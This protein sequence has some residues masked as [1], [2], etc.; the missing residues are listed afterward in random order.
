MT[1]HVANLTGELC[2]TY[3]CVEPTGKPDPIDHSRV[4]LLRC[5]CGR[6]LFMPLSRIRRYQKH[7]LYPRCFCPHYAAAAVNRGKRLPDNRPRRCSGCSG[8]DHKYKDCP[9]R[10]PSKF[11]WRCCDMTFR[12][13]GPKCRSCG[14]VY[15]PEAP[16]E[17]DVEGA[18]ASSIA[19]CAEVA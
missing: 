19:R 4:W 14:L 3:R 2:G 1:R 7:N 5:T 8:T 11:C 12:V 10:K 6:E 18:R 15:A 16:V 17:L 13:V 9:K